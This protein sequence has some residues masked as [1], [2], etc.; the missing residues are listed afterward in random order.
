MT[1]EQLANDVIETAFKN[2]NGDANTIKSLRIALQIGIRLGVIESISMIKNEDD[3]TR[4]N[5]YLHEKHDLEV[6]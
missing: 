2:V 4:L 3:I 5:E 1:I 6:A